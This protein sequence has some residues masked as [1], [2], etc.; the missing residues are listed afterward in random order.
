MAKNCSICSSPQAVQEQI[1]QWHKDGKSYRDMETSLA[2]EYKLSLSNS[3]IRRHLI[4]CIGAEK[5]EGRKEN[6]L[7]FQE[8]IN[9]PKPDGADMHNALCHIL[10]QGIEMFFQRMKETGEKTTPYN[11][12]L[13][14]Y[15]CLEMLIK[16]LESLYPNCGRLAEIKAQKQREIE[17]KSLTENT[18]YFHQHVLYKMLTLKR[19]MTP[20]EYRK[21]VNTA[22]DHAIIGFKEEQKITSE[23][24]EE[25]KSEEITA[26]A[27]ETLS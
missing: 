4:N 2:E 25:E 12:H 22:I 11:V 18:N 17:M 16:M 20:E 9:T 14:T 27:S 6:I 15:R 23:Q 26:E 1:L 3:S 13:E 10:N 19:K 5:D 8:V 24:Q 21:Y 7:T